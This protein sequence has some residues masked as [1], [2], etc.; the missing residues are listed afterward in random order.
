MKHFLL[1]YLNPS[2]SGSQLSKCVSRVTA[3]KDIIMGM[4][5]RYMRM[6]YCT[7]LSQT[8]KNIVSGMV[9]L[10]DRVARRDEV[11]K[12]PLKKSKQFYLYN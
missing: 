4:A 7:P 1:M 5:P 10:S 6:E 9:R 12:Q 3:M 11:R 8:S 2:S